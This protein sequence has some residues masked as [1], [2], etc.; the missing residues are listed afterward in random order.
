MCPVIFW[1]C[2]SSMVSY[3]CEVKNQ[4]LDRYTVSINIFNIY[5]M[6]VIPDVCSKYFILSSTMHSDIMKITII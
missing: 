2:E 3:S 6:D 1:L 5:I 4:L